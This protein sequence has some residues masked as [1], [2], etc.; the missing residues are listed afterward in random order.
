MLHVYVCVFMCIHKGTTGCIS[1][2]MVTNPY[3]VFFPAVCVF[4]YLGKVCMDTSAQ[5][6]LVAE[7]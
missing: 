4:C 7:V 5:R 3:L 1:K 6:A 2:V